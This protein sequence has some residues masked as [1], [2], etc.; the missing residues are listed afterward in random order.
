M[1]WA[2]RSCL[3]CETGINLYLTKPVHPWAQ[4]NKTMGDSIEYCKKCKNNIGCHLNRGCL[5][6]SFK[7]KKI[8]TVASPVLFGSSVLLRRG[9]HDAPAPGQFRYVKATY[10]GARGFYVCCR[11]EQDDPDDGVGYSTK[12]GDVGWWGR[13]IMYFPND[14]LEAATNEYRIQQ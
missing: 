10:I 13:S 6:E 12:K 8:P 2:A 11:L 1:K 5:T 7:T 3:G 4:L 14:Q 9:G